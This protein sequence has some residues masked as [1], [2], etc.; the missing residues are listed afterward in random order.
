VEPGVDLTLGSV[1]M[2]T[3]FGNLFGRD[4]WVTWDL[5]D[6]TFTIRISKTRNRAT[7]FS[8]LVVEND[9]VA[10]EAE[11]AAAEAEDA[12]EETEAGDQ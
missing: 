6:D 7:P 2:V 3:P 8:W 9:A 5:E 11:A 4:F 12:E 1:I 10:A